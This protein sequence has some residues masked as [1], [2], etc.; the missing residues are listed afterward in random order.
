VSRSANPKLIGSFVVGAAAVVV[1][2][3]LLLSDGGFWR[4]R[5]E[6][7]MYFEG[8]TTGLQVGSPVVFR[9]VK[10]GS[11]QNIGLSV[12]AEGEKINFLVP[13]T[14]RTDEFVLTDTTGKPV[15]LGDIAENSELIKRGLRAR[16]KTWSFLTGQ[17]Y[18]D[19]DFYPDRPLRLYRQGKGTREIPTLPT[20][21]QELT[22]KLDKLNLE[23]LFDDFSTTLEAVRN[24]VTSPEA[25]RMMESLDE[26]L[27]HLASLSA[28][29]DASANRVTKD[30]RDVMREAGETLRTTREA[31]AES[32]ETIRASRTTL[33]RIDEGA[34]NFAALARPDSPLLQSVTHAG[35]DMAAAAR[36]LRAAADDNSTTRLRLDE[37]LEETASAAR[38]LRLLAEALETDPRSVLTGRSDEDIR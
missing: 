17:L 36:A 33:A 25:A 5:T 23:Q 14:I 22:N 11:V 2:A 30:T 13:V 38:A 35:E 1:A 12:S 28:R 18:I 26:T 24:L 8:S 37:L 16:L 21:V 32:T 6:Y 7:I 31:L 10:I 3:V 19:L 15:E 9:G 34:A 29:L 4:D 20:E 27:Q